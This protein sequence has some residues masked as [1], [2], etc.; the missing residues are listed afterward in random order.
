ML[1]VGCDIVQIPRIARLIET[2]G[3]AFLT[4]VFT[5]SERETATK[6][7]KQ[8]E[9]YAAHFAKR[10]AAKE[11]FAK[12]LGSGFGQTIAMQDVGVANDAKGAPFFEFSDKAKQALTKQFGDKVS[13]SLSLSDDAPQAMAF[14]VIHENKHG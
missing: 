9:K 4:R 5:I 6:F 10:F 11:A 1:A 2:K 12:A 13:V 7:A 3:D 8:S 14:V